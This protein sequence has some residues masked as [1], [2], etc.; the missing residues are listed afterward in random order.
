MVCPK[1]GGNNIDG[2][3]FCI[4]CGTNLNE[5]QQSINVT[6]AIMPN[7]QSEPVAAQ[8]PATPSQQVYRNN[9]QAATLD[10]ASYAVNSLVKPVDAFKAE[11]NN[12]SDIKNSGIF[13]LIVAGIM[14]FINLITT[15]LLTARTY[16]YDWNKGYTY[17]WKFDKLKDLNYIQLIGKNFLIYLAIIAAIAIVYYIGS[18]I[19]KKQLN[20]G[21]SVAISATAL[22]PSMI[23]IMLLAPISSLIWAD[24]SIIFSIIGFIYSFIVLYELMNSELNLN[25]NIKVFFN[26]ACLSVLVVTSYYILMKVIANALVSGLSGLLG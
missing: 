17:V 24:L 13:A 6:Q 12:F 16:T 26:A 1:C 15:M 25:G 20:F 14:T 5:L 23:G 11:A 22:I 2:S 8:A 4:S 7:V 9:T 19:I 21:K 18:L 3:T 10:L